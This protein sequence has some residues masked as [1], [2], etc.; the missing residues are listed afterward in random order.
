MQ[1]NLSFSCISCTNMVLSLQIC[2]WVDYSTRPYI[3][4]YITTRFYIGYLSL[5]DCN[6]SLTYCYYYWI[7]STLLNL[8][9]FLF[10]GTH[11]L[12]QPKLNVSVMTSEGEYKSLVVSISLSDPVDLS[13]FL[14]EC[15]W[16][17]NR[18]GTYR[19]V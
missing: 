8:S 7:I 14:C 10:R 9:L 19:Y 16:L 3:M 5:I 6:W 15:Q 12:S 13:V 18:N 1:Q 4:H 17:S 11:H 2:T